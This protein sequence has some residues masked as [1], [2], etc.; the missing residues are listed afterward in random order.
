MPKQSDDEFIDEVMR[1][2]LMKSL[3]R[4]AV[5][6]Q[7]QCSDCGAILD[8]EKNAVLIDGTAGKGGIACCCTKCADRFIA[9]VK[10]REEAA[11]VKVMHLIEITDCRELKDVVCPA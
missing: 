2:P 3:L 7:I 6:R 4:F 11:G 9:K 10:A 5:Q 1:R 8:C